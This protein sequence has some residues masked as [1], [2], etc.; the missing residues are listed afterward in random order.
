MAWVTCPHCGFTQ[1]PAAQCL[2]CKKRIDRPRE[3]EPAPPPPGPSV[4]ASPVAI[5]SAIPRQYLLV[6]AGLALAVITAVLLWGS[7][8][9]GTV[10]VAVAP[11]PTTP[12]PWTLDLTGRWE[13]KVATTITGSPRGRPCARSSSRP[14][15]RAT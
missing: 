11:P 8:S 15:A 10:A 9:S 3:G 5:L 4:P 2:K 13:G 12:E 1:I 14:T 7:R 6:L